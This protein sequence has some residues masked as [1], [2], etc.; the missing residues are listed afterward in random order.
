M[1]SHHG[2]VQHACACQPFDRQS[3][4]C[5][6]C[7]QLHHLCDDS[8]SLVVLVVFVAVLL[9]RLDMGVI[10]ICW[11]VVNVRSLSTDDCLLE[12]GSLVHGPEHTPDATCALNADESYHFKLHA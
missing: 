1:V 5:T 11:Q 9:F 7:I 6:Q 8:F 4:P 2:R 10:V 12:I 3:S